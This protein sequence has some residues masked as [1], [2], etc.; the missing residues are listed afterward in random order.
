MTWNSSIPSSSNFHGSLLID[1]QIWPYE[2]SGRSFIVVHSPR[3]ERCLAATQIAPFFL[4]PSVWARFQCI[5]VNVC[6]SVCRCG[7]Q[8]GDIQEASQG[9]LT[10]WHFSPGGSC[11][12]RQSGWEERTFRSCWQRQKLREKDSAVY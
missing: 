2:R 7:L 3:C 6:N 1:I 8:S 12:P 11:S 5:F 4:L 9:V 10:S